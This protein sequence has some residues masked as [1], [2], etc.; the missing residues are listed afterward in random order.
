MVAA[1][2]SRRVRETHHL[3]W[4][5]GS[6]LPI[7]QFGIACWSLFTPSSVTPFLL[8]LDSLFILSVI[9]R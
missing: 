3:N 9:N 6:Y 4:R 8:W 2:Q 1:L 5:V 7:V